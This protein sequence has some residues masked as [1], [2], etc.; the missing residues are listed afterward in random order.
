MNKLELALDHE[1]STCPHAILRFKP[2]LCPLVGG[3]TQ[4]DAGGATCVRS[5]E[6]DGETEPDDQFTQEGEIIVRRHTGD[7]CKGR[8]GF[9]EECVHSG[10]GGQCIGGRLPEG[11]GKKKKDINLL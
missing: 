6:T 1:Q 7:G 9:H 10:D 3:T 11:I 2:F 5:M 4:H 8:T